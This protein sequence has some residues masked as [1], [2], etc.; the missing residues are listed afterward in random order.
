M[1][2]TVP[3]SVVPTFAPAHDSTAHDSTAHDS[4]AVASGEDSIDLDQ[5]ASLL[6][7]RLGSFSLPMRPD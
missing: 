4:D 7:E 5:L 2:L 3:A 6:N 1:P